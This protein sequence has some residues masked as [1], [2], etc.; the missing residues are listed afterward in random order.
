MTKLT[1]KDLFDLKGKRTF[2]QVFVRTPKQAAACYAAGI[3]MIVTSEARSITAKI[4]ELAPDI[5]ITVAQGY[6]VHPSIRESL[7]SAYKAI[8]D[9]ADAIYC[10]QSLDTINALAK[11]G[12]PA[13][14]HIGLVPY[15]STWSG[16]FKAVGKTAAEAKKVYDLGMRY[17]DA[18]AIGVEME[19]V[20]ADVAAE[21]SRRLNIFTLGM[22]CGSGCDAQY[23]FAEDIL[24]N[25][26]GHVP[27][28]AKVYRDHKSEY[29][30]LYQ[31]SIEAF[32]EL[33]ADVDSGAYP[34]ASHTIKTQP[35]ELAEFIRLLEN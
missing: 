16:G 26:T 28:H 14:G 4:R 3:D 34:E 6:G 11:E 24:G 18:G 31:D 10:P 27:R 8:Q 23:L 1:V 21:I 13:V 5:F 9:G 30:R 15:K 7:I 33:K 2:T 22:G 32:R 19:I 17:Q 20:P 29:E 35:D 12:I 25:N